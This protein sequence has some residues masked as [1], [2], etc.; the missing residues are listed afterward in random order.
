M[1]NMAHVGEQE[2]QYSRVFLHNFYSLP[3]IIGG[4]QISENEMSELYIMHG[5]MRNEN[6]ILIRKPEAKRP[7]WGYRHR[8]EDNIKMNLRE[9]GVRV[10][11]GFS[12]LKT[13]SV[14]RP[15]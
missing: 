11:S 1:K 15:L 8:W 5:E 7:L 2:V 13:R 12:W 3:N 10:Q 9:V 14:G 4:N 6:K